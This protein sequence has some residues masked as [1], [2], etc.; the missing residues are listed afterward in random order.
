MKK[1][2]LFMLCL[3]TTSLL[4]AQL[5]Y[6]NGTVAGG[7]GFAG[8]VT[9]GVS[10]AGGAPASVLQGTNTSL[11][12]G[13]QITAF[14][15]VSDDFVVSTPVLL[16][17]L[18]F[19]AYQTGSPTTSTINDVRVRIYNGPPNAGGVIIYG[20]TITNR[21]AS[22]SWSGIYRTG[23]TTPTDATRPIMTVKVNIS[24]ALNLAAGTYW[25]E[26]NCG[27]TLASGPWAPVLNHNTAF[28]AGNAIQH[29]ST[30]FSWAPLLDGGSTVQMG[31]PFLVYGTPPCAMTASSSS[32]DATCTA[33]NGSA[34]VT[35]T[36]GT[37]PLTYLWS[38]AGNTATINNLAAGAYTVTVTDASGCSA[39]SSIT[40]S[41]TSTAITA[42]TSSTNSACGVPSGTATATPTNGTAPYSYNW[43][44]G[45]NSQTINGLVAG[46]YA[47]TVSDANG[48]MGTFSGIVVANPS[49]PT[50]SISAQTNIACFAG[51]NGSATASATGGT[52]PYGY[53]WSNGAITATATGLVAG[54]YTVTV[55]DAATCAST[56]SVVI[57]QP[58][59]ALSAPATAT[60]VSCFGGTN[61]AASVTAAGGTT[62]YTYAW[63][64][65]GTSAS[66]SNLAAGTYQVTVTDAN[67]CVASSSVTI[68]EPTALIASPLSQTNIACFGDATGAAAVTASGG[69]SPYTYAWSP[70]GGNAANATGLTAN[71]YTVVISDANNCTVSQ[72][73][74]ITQ[75][76]AIAS[77]VTATDATTAGG[78]DGSVNITV[79]GGTAPYTY[80]WSNSVATEDLTAVAA[81]T[82]TVTITDANGC[83]STASGTVLDGPIAV[84]MTNNNININLFPNPTADN[85][86]LSIE[87]ANM[88]DVNITI[89]NVVGQ[90]MQSMNATAL[91]NKQFTLNMSDWA[92]GIYFVRVNVGN[93]TATYRLTKK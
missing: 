9:P 32:T 85:A 30:T 42:N 22:T 1:L 68:T 6:D 26:W 4:S 21:L 58:A 49:A 90:V 78:N 91:T 37:A 45:G 69:T 79:S 35:A 16:D 28:G 76:T 12:A 18:K 24:P 51:N 40:V 74:T 89:T 17:S 52:A 27:G 66:E 80:E 59:M 46:S 54:T 2:I 82:Y 50:S 57:T 33:N 41:T 7:S 53:A 23:G 15:R 31:L 64:S 65:A 36:G 55:I 75:P 60:N 19:F 73:F 72:A 5:I 47:V 44:N 84:G 8:L 88:A 61:G 83:T 93:D 67:A 63:S 43:S 14:N 25:V 13:H 20:D 71:S 86:T 38:N 87:L 34:M 3:G 92:A 77:T 81:G 48:C 29:T 39:T 56:T 11:G 10:G 70:A 62:P